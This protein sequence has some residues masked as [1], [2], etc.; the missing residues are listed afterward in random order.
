[1]LAKQ[2]WR[3]L[4]N[5]EALS[6]R[7]LKAVCYPNSELLEANL[8]SSPSQVWRALIEGRDVLKQGII[9]RI[10]TGEKTNAW[11]HNWLP[12]DFMLRPLV[13]KKANPPLQV[14]AFIDNTTATWK[15]D[16]L[17]ECF[18]PMDVEVI[19]SIPLSTQRMEDLWAWHY[20]KNGV[21]TVRSVYRLL[22]ET[23]RRRED[24]L[25]GRAAGSNRERVQSLATAV[26]GTSSI[27]TA[28]FPLAPC[29]TLFAD[30]GCSKPQED[31]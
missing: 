8:G 26:E 29:P 2:A 10:G 22:V 30:R 9:R 21:P 7:I 20:E 17:Q 27:K 5:P 23:K 6:S 18:I 15:S 12:R 25:D 3:I 4:K 24:W 28:Y 19:Q 31:G 11:D 13:C 16:I 1:M 14:A